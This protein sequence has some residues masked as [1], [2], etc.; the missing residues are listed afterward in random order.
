MS[1]VD[2]LARWVEFAENSPTQPVA[3]IVLD[4]R[5][6]GTVVRTKDALGQDFLMMAP[7]VLNRVQREPA[8]PGHIAG[9]PV[10]KREDMPPG[11]P[12]AL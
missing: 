8:A 2:D 10:L 7:A 11:W 12:D 3:Y 5:V 6:G 9:I 4:E 1:V